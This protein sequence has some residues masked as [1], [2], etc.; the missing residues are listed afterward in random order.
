MSEPRFDAAIAALRDGEKHYRESAD[1][2]TLDILRLEAKLEDFRTQREQACKRCDEYSRAIA[3]LQ[4][5]EYPEY[6]N[7]GIDI[8]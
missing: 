5:V 3:K 7:S 1:A 8:D 6:K 4:R 2:M